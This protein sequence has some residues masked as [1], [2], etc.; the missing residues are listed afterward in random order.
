MKT[1]Y[2]EQN[3]TYITIRISYIP[4]GLVT[5]IRAG[6]LVILTSFSDKG[7]GCFSPHHPTDSRAHVAPYVLD[8]GNKAV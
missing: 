8:V 3:R 2:T 5:R 6:Q 4:V 7:R 1:E